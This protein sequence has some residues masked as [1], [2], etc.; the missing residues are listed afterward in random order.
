MTSTAIDAP[1]HGQRLR[2]LG[3]H[4]RACEIDFWHA[5]KTRTVQFMAG[6][7]SLLWGVSLLP[8]L[9]RLSF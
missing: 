8:M 2:I 1:S 6:L 4:I 9:I 3:R 5:A 7:A